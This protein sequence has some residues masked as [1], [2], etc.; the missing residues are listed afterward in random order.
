MDYAGWRYLKKPWR[1]DWE[2]DPCK[3]TFLK[4]PTV[5]GRSFFLYNDFVD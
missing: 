1:C 5:D 4:D 3:I 2:Y